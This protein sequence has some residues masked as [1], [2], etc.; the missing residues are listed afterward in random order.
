MT[1]LLIVAGAGAHGDPWHVLDDTAAALAEVLRPLGE[2]R[3]VSTG[4]LAGLPA[5][6]APDLVVCDISGP[7]EGTGGGD[8]VL[9]RLLAWHAGGAPVLAVHSAVL[10]F[11]DDD[12][13]FALLGA[14]WREGVS[15]H[16]PL[17][18]ADV[19]STGDS[20]AGIRL[21]GFRTIDE[22]YSDLELA[23]ADGDRVVLAEHV[24][25]GRQHPL[26]WWRAAGGAPV[27]VSLLGHDA[28]AYA[29]A[30]Y[31]D[32]L[33]RLAAGLLRG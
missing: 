1:D 24:E 17:G 22:R 31:A 18:P 13:W 7:P 19:R 30:D 9:E 5:S 21:A 26:I 14:R 12:R 2:V 10:A 15:G 4:E 6:P 29:S 33:R 20:A 32:A 3:V 27:A 16:P 23:D 25:Q 11:R 8:P 28:R